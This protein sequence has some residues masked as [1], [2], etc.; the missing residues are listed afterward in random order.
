MTDSQNGTLHMAQLYLHIPRLI[1]LGRA[2]HLPIHSTDHNYITHCALHELFGDGA[3]G[4]FCIEATSDRSLR[5]VAY[6]DVPAEQLQQAARTAASPMAY[7]ICDWGRLATKPMPTRFA[8][9][10]PLRFELRACP[11][12]RKSADGKYHKAGTEVDAFLSRV[13]EVDDPDVP[14]N[15]EEVYRHWLVGHLERSGGTKLQSVRLTRFS[16]ERMTRRTQG[17]DRTA[18]TIKRPAATLD[19]E[20][21]VADSSAFAEL[22]R[23][24]IGRHRSFGFGML[25]IR[26]AGR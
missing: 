16:I 18:R 1:E 23:K 22:L 20:L 19:G 25:K 14:V 10:T 13:W 21:V 5:L 7:N 6:A 11:V 8:E 15:R 17:G 24:G 3:P 4:P 26:P 2:L 12:V 9:G